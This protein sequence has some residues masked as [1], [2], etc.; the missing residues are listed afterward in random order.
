MITI[1]NK[2]IK[3]EVF[4]YNPELDVRPHYDSFKVPYRKGMTV[5]D[6]LIYIHENIDPTLVFRYECKV[7]RCGSC[8]V[9]VNEIP[10]LACKTIINREEIRIKPLQGSPIIRDLVVDLSKTYRRFSVLGPLF[11]AKNL[12]TGKL[13]PMRVPESLIEASKCIECSLCDNICPVTNQIPAEFVG[14]MRLLALSQSAH[15][16]LNII[17]NLSAMPSYGL[18]NCM[19]CQL[20]TVVCPMKINI[21]DVATKKLRTLVGKK[22][23]LPSEVED[24]LAALQAEGNIFGR[25]VSE[26]ARSIDTVVEMQEKAEIALFFGCVATYIKPEVMQN[27]MKILSRMGIKFTTLGIKEQCCGYP[28]LLWGAK[29]IAKELAKRNIEQLQNSGVNRAC[30]VCPGCYKTFKTDYP[31]LVGQMN[32]DIVH[33]SELLSELIDERKIVFKREV[34]LRVTYHDPCEL[35]RNFGIFDPP[36]KIITT[37]PGV[38]LVEMPRSRTFALCCGAGGGVRNAN[39]HLALK[40]AA[41]RVREAEA[42]GVDAI[43]SACPTCEWNLQTAIRRRH[44][45]LRV[46]DVTELLAESMN[47]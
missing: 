15:N 3:I 30:V 34:R 31:Q 41:E 20:C 26:K 22:N 33:I 2:R 40:I 13:A 23:L 12:E 27:A 18:H 24:S 10:A 7:G 46:L 8:T 16:P 9:L 1:S 6:A 47:L 32:I 5:L 43:I 28:A 38:K 17:D 4:R 25:V 35:G 19:T 36:R 11:K 42:L 45:K 14:P 39:I 21:S 44:S 37:I 29:R